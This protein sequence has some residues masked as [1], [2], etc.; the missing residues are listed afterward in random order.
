MQ[1]FSKNFI[2]AAIVAGLVV[3]LVSFAALVPFGGKVITPPIFCLNGGI[4]FKVVGFNLGS[5]LG[6]TFAPGSIPF[7]WGPPRIGVDVLGTADTPYPCQVSVTPPVTLPSL[8]VFMTGT[9]L[10]I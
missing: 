10:G 6:Y 4:Y 9:G 3:P 8:R 7:S 5:A 2:A 1:R